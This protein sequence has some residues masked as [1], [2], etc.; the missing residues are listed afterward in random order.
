MKGLSAFLVLGLAVL[1]GCGSSSSGS[2]GN[3]AG[4]AGNWQ[5]TLNYTKYVGKAAPFV[6]Y[7]GLLPGGSGHAIYGLGNNLADRDNLALSIRRTF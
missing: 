3:T 5:F 7:S 6:D 4:L 2:P 1:T